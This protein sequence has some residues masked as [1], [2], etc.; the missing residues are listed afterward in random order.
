[1]AK[2][3]H[4]KNAAD[5]KILQEFERLEGLFQ[6]IR[7]GELYL[8]AGYLPCA[9]AFA[10]S[11]EYILQFK[12]DS[13]IGRIYEESADVLFECACRDMHREA[14]QLYHYLKETKIFVYTEIYA[15]ID[16][17]GLIQEKLANINSDKLHASVFYA[18]YRSANGEQ[19]V[20]DIYDLLY[21]NRY[22]DFLGK[23]LTGNNHF[24]IPF[25]ET[26]LKSCVFHAQ[27]TAGIL[28]PTDVS[29][30]LCLPEFWDSWILF[31]EK[32]QRDDNCNWEINLLQDA[33]QGGKHKVNLLKQ[34][35]LAYKEKPAL[36]WDALYAKE[37]D[38]DPAGVTEIGKEALDQLDPRLPVYSTI[39]LWLARAAYRKKEYALAQS[40]CI[41]ALQSELTPPIMWLL[42]FSLLHEPEKQKDAVLSLVRERRQKLGRTTTSEWFD[43]LDKDS[44]MA[45]FVSEQ[46]TGIIQLF[47]GNYEAFVNFYESES[48]MTDDLA[49]ASAL[50]L[51][52]LKDCVWEKGCQYM[53]KLVQGHLRFSHDRYV[54]AVTELSG[55]GT[56][57]DGFFQECFLKWKSW[58]QTE[59]TAQKY[60]PVLERWVNRC[61]RENLQERFFRQAAAFAVALGELYESFGEKDGKQHVFEK[62]RA[63]FAA[64][65]KDSHYFH[66]HNG[67][68]PYKKAFELHLY[69]FESEKPI[70]VCFDKLC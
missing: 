10:L 44:Q 13:G 8:R 9:A 3:I 42:A 1:M 51:L 59:F 30:Y 70:E 50:L 6:K 33:S 66:R 36:Y 55:D 57:M 47:L 12:D 37:L 62:C 21:K 7:N 45:L 61:I 32:H 31:L 26:W 5:Q 38:N 67:D 14:I 65:I 41:Q 20:Q 68:F 58:H 52:L 25:L 2:Q 27:E 16:I 19:R 46:N 18:V 22:T 53:A 4:M 24:T 56:G 34:A 43:L 69:G 39:A 29:E 15:S 23:D 40:Y 49:Y 63:E 64:N 60:L 11:P 35:R 54:R 17:K 28:E 48:A